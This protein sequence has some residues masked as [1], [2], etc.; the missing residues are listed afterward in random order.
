MNRRSL[1][2]G[3]ARLLYAGC[4]AVVAAP[5]VGY[6]LEP[7][8]RRAG[9]TRGFNRV[10][11]LS[12]LPPETPRDYPIRDVRTDAWTVYPLETIGRVWLI[13]R[14]AKDT[15]PDRCQVDAYSMVCPHLGCSVT[16]QAGN[17]RFFCPCHKAAFHPSAVRLTTE[18]L[19][20]KNPSPRDMDQL[21][22]QIV[23]DEASQW[24]VE[25][26]YQSFRLGR[27]EKLAEG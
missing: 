15:P 18:E 7:F 8:R 26:R 27:A 19:G 1:L 10:A 16:W 25:V 11:K 13:R 20:Q 9:A 3:L 17:H 6:V 22:T 2:A 14:S 24:W 5:V 23:K 4:A 21:E 12:D